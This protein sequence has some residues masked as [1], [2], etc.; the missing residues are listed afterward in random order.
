M[1]TATIRLQNQSVRAA[2]I[3]FEAITKKLLCSVRHAKTAFRIGTI[4]AAIAVF[5]VYDRALFVAF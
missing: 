1:P 4:A 2:C 5:D 3:V